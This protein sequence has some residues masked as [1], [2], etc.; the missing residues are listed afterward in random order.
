MTLSLCGNYT[1]VANVRE[2][3]PKEE[4]LEAAAEDSRRNMLWQTIPNTV[5][6]FKTTKYIVVIV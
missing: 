3:A 4:S 2:T 5:I 6:L 1:G